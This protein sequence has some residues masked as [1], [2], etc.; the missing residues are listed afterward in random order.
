M[1]RDYAAELR[2][3][4]CKEKVLDLTTISRNFP[5]RSRTSLVRD[6]RKV[7]AI[8]SYNHC[9][10]HYTLKEIAEFDGQGIWQY[11]D[12]LFSDHGN[13][14]RTIQTMVDNSSSGLTHNELQPTLRLRTHDVL[15]EMVKHNKIA[16]ADVHN[17]YVYVSADAEAGQKQVEARVAP[18]QQSFAAQTGPL[19]II[20]VLSYVLRNPGTTADAAHSHFKGAG[21]SQG[22]VEEI[23]ERYVDGKKN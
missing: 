20:E 23:F 21:V 14:K 11:G 4:F 17:N 18:P 6:L 16:R 7:G 19:L 1:A 15:R 3:L 8:A 12:A 9:G 5:G 22:E 13:L 10:K 2:A